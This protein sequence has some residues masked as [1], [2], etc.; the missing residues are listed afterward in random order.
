MATNHTPGPW[1]VGGREFIRGSEV[2]EVSG[3]RSACWLAKVQSQLGSFDGSGEANAH[4]ISAAPELLAALDA[5]LTAV[6][7]SDAMHSLPDEV[8]AQIEA[9]I[10]KAR[11]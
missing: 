8:M 6:R 10:L 11:G 4:L 2:I 3:E 9:A 5:T 1:K 7:N